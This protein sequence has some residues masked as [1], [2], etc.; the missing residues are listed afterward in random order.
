[1]R[2]FISILCISSLSLSPISIDSEAHRAISLNYQ[3]VEAEPLTLTLIGIAV[4]LAGIA[5]DVYG[6]TQNNDISVQVAE[7]VNQ[8][9][10]NQIKMGLSPLKK[11]NPKLKRLVNGQSKLL[12]GQ[13]TI[14]RGQ[15]ALQQGQ[16]DLQK[17]QMALQRG[18]QAIMKN[19]MMLRD[20]QQK[21]LR[22][23]TELKRGQEEL[24]SGQMALSEQ[25]VMVATELKRRSDRGERLMKTLR[26]ENNTLHKETQSLIVGL[27]EARYSAAIRLIDLA[28][29]ATK[30]QPKQAQSWLN[31]ALTSL[32][33]SQ[34]YFSEQS[35]AGK[36]VS[37]E[38]RALIHLSLATCYLGLNMPE[39]GVREVASLVAI[40]SAGKGIEALL[41]TSRTLALDTSLEQTFKEIRA[42]SNA[43]IDERLRLAKLKKLAVRIIRSNPNLAALWSKV[44]NQ[45]YGNAAIDERELALQAFA[46]AASRHSKELDESGLEVIADPTSVQGQASIVNG[47]IYRATSSTDVHKGR[48]LSALRSAARAFKEVH[49]L[50]EQTIKLAESPNPLDAEVT[51]AR[52]SYQRVFAQF[53]A[54]SHLSAELLACVER[55]HKERSPDCN[56]A[57]EIIEKTRRSL[58]R[59]D[60]AIDIQ[61]SSR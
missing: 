57:L 36:F 51:R 11:I 33:E 26:R 15:A 4:G 12:A 10:I 53:A 2:V 21:I 27:Q 58:E 30:T 17:G 3:T 48:E 22:G 31:A 18:Q 9:T 5:T 38:Y 43:L 55:G 25:L 34:A 45:A 40:P 44:D 29:K 42:W 14:K 6:M 23:Q 1:M 46:I 49:K 13:E 24:R 8:V 16:A 54:D 41:N 61:E 28:G 19:Q 7:Q 32:L 39:E 20:G 60:E 52:Q 56:D 35:R 50:S 59:I 37:R 47:S